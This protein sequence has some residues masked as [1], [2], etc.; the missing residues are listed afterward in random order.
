MHLG[1]DTNSNGAVD[2]N[3]VFNKPQHKS[4]APPRRIGVGCRLV[5]TEADLAKRRLDPRANAG[6]QQTGAADLAHGSG[7]KVAENELHVDIVANQLRGQSVA[8]LLEEG[9]A[10]RVGGQVRGG[11]PAAEGAHGEDETALALLEDRGN[12]LGDLERADAVDGDDALELVGGGIEERDGNV[13]ALADVVDEDTDVK[14]LDE[15]A[16]GVVVGVVVLGKVHGQR[17]DLDGLDRV[18]GGDFGGN[19]IELRLGSRDEDEVE[20]LGG[21]LGGKLLAEAVGGASD[22]GPGAGLSI[23]AKLS[24]RN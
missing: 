1:I 19:G 21:E 13:V 20:A 17:L 12:D 10:A 7:D 22:Y 3:R 4:V 18:L 5:A 8:P 6:D 15:L 14:A 11:S 24:E 9:L 23:L 16:E 2:A